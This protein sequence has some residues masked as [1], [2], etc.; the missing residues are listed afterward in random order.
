MALAEATVS[1]YS[2]LAVGDNWWQTVKPS[3]PPPNGMH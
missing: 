2:S 3:H 1:E